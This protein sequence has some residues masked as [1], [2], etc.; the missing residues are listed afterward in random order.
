[1]K[2]ATLATLEEFQWLRRTKTDAQKICI[3]C[4]KKSIEGHKPE[5]EVAIAIR[6]NGGEPLMAKAA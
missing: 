5:C 2:N 6:E 4:G 3:Y 1:M